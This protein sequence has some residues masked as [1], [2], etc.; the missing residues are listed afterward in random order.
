MVLKKLSKRF[1]KKERNAV[2]MG[3]FFTVMFLFIG[4]PIYEWAVETYSLSYLQTI[5]VGVIF[6]VLI[7][8]IFEFNQK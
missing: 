8:V 7:G 5:I 2:L 1:K 4:N 6:A 3:A